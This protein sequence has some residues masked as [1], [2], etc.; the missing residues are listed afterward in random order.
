MEDRPLVSVVIPTFNSERYIGKCLQSVRNQTY[1]NIEIIVVDKSSED[2]T[3][4]IAKKYQAKIFHFEYVVDKTTQIQRNI[5]ISKAEG[6]YLFSMDSDFELTPKVV[7]ESLEVISSDEKIGGVII[8]K[9]SVGK[10]YWV[11]VRD[12]ERSFYAGTEVE[13][14][15]FF[16]MD[17]V[18]K[19]GGYDGAVTC[20]EES[21]LPQKIEKFGHKVKARISSH[22]LH[23]EEDFSL[24][25]WL[26]KKYWYGKSGGEYSLEKNYGKKRMRVFRRFRIFLKNKRFY[27]K[28]I[29]AVSV[30]TLKFLEFF[31]VR[32]GFLKMKVRKG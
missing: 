19:V 21:T 16:R 20:F 9:R 7:E 25:R 1:D 26:K 29:L 28:P 27:S 23:P 32:L 5:G 6:E 11:N 3:V 12:F 17:L 30:L 15:R 22:L 24:I 31:S 2:K 14:A 4:E 18:R 13:S 8:P 10:S